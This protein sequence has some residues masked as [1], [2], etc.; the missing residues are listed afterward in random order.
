MLAVLTAVAWAALLAAAQGP[1]GDAC[2]DAEAAAR[3]PDM[4]IDVNTAEAALLEVLPGIGGTLAENIVVDRRANGL[5]ESL[6]E[7][8]RVPRIGPK[9]IEKMRPYVVVGEEVPG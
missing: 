6:G 8:D 3:R 5:Y 2:G 9:T 4:R 1:L 7:L